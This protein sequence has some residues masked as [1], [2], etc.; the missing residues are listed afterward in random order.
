MIM[1]EG[2]VSDSYDDILEIPKWDAIWARYN[3][4]IYNEGLFEQ[5]VQSWINSKA[6]Y[7]S[8]G[9]NYGRANYINPMLYSD[10]DYKPQ[11]PN[12][13][14]GAA[15]PGASNRDQ[16]FWVLYDH[17]KD[18]N[19]PTS[20]Y[21]K[22]E[23]VS[24]K[25]MRARQLYGINNDV[26]SYPD[27]TKDTVP[28]QETYK[29]GYY[30]HPSETNRKRLSSYPII[31][32]L[33][34]NSNYVFY[35]DITKGN[36]KNAGFNGVAREVAEE[37]KVIENVQFT[38]VEYLPTVTMLEKSLRP[39][40]MPSVNCMTFANMVMMGI[41]YEN[42]RINKPENHIGACGYGFDVC[43]YLNALNNGFDVIEKTLYRKANPDE[44]I[45]EIS[46]PTKIRYNPKKTLNAKNFQKILYQDDYY[47]TMEKL[48]LCRH[49]EAFYRTIESE[50][51]KKIDTYDQNKVKKYCCKEAGT[52]E[53]KF[54]YLTYIA[55][56][57]PGDILHTTGSYLT[58][59]SKKG[60]SLDGSHSAICLDV[61]YPT[62]INKNAGI[63]LVLQDSTTEDGKKVY[64]WENNKLLWYYSENATDP[65]YKKLVNDNDDSV[66]KLVIAH[67]TGSGSEPDTPQK[68][69]VLVNGFG[70]CGV[71]IPVYNS[72]GEALYIREN[73]IDVY[74]NLTNDSDKR[75]LYAFLYYNASITFTNKNGENGIPVWKHF[76]TYGNNT[77]SEN[78]SSGNSIRNYNIIK[79][80]RPIYQYYPAL[81]FR[82]RIPNNGAD[83]DNY[84]EE[85]EYYW[86]GLTSLDI[87]KMKNYPFS[88]LNRFN[89]SVKPLY[90]EGYGALQSEWARHG[91][92][93]LQTLTTSTGGLAIRAI[94]Q[95]K[96]GTSYEK[97]W[98]ILSDTIE[99]D[100]DDTAGLAKQDLDN[101]SK[102]GKYASLHALN[103]TNFPNAP[104][105][106]GGYFVLE[107]KKM[108]A[109]NDDFTIKP[110]SWK[111]G[112][113]QQIITAM[114]GSYIYRRQ[115]CWPESEFSTRTTPFYGD[116]Y[117]YSGT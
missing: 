111:Q 37:K 86:I 100:S 32:L 53:K 27:G 18:D 54:P 31:P 94:G 113:Y 33:D 38:T 55:H 87:T 34:R 89:L 117:K 19:N 6:V 80:V 45:E 28:T 51:S 110:K 21:T 61:T 35:R 112:Y 82:K 58:Y 7:G 102:V 103:S 106:V 44:K 5:C 43:K 109:L 15:T 40:R 59:S 41:N 30:Q 101:V 72:K 22:I 64:R 9:N 93:Y 52:D 62:S 25:L 2:I 92:Y 57:H 67:G 73:I 46:L 20:D 78:V 26:N 13:Q 4:K 114:D 69:I 56:V 23:T 90:G 105:N 49:T 24:W 97:S 91:Q 95:S 36:T 85:G 74:D 14:S 108:R 16:M 116:W 68:N 96:D 60:K 8:L 79:I 88:T 39:I 48:G 50:G 65:S 84:S 75:R 98:N 76:V 81:P 70:E 83:L 29:N 107:V 42:S 66:V 99:Q 17:V 77:T 11:I 47:D 12:G 71:K 3:S 1:S 115:I 104:A 63:K 10:Y